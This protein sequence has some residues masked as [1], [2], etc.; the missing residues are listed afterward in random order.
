[1]SDVIDAYLAE[2][3][4]RLS[5]S[6]QARDALLEEVRGHLEET[7]ARLE[8]QGAIAATAAEQAITAF[9]APG[10]VAARFNAVHA[11]RWDLHR[12][13]MG[14][15]IGALS[16]YVVWTLVTYPLLV[17]LA[18]QDMPTHDGSTALALLFR[19]T[20]L[21]F[22]LFGVVSRDA[23]WLVPLLLLL[24]GALL[25]AWGRR[26]RHSWRPGCAYGLGAVVGMPWLLPAIP[27][28]W[29]RGS[30]AALLLAVGALWLLLPYT[31]LASWA[32]GR[33][34]WAGGRTARAGLSLALR[35][36]PRL[37]RIT[38]VGATAV[39]APQRR[40]AVLALP[41]PS[42]SSCW[43]STRH[44]SSAR[45]PFPHLRSRRCQTS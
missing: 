8:A 37:H 7:A 15:L 14:G 22:G 2:L 33:T 35:R 5:A 10:A 4:R 29:G 25:F 28:Q 17:Q 30:L 36:P 31:M 42:C 38:A 11:V 44:H 34:A 16:L 12:M 45:P 27:L 13:L 43:P 9:G 23:L 41:G 3:A 6:P 18:T 32:G 40:F 26:A 19:A 20:P 21:A 1:M 39:R 24:F